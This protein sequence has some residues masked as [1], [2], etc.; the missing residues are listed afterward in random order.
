MTLLFLFTALLLAVLNVALIISI[1]AP[2]ARAWPPPGQKSWQF[3]ALWS[4]TIL[5]FGCLGLLGI[6]DWNRL[7]W[8]AELRWPVGLGLILAGNA[9]A[10]VGLTQLG[11]R[12]SSGGIGELVTS[13]IYKHSR[14]PAYIGDILILLEWV[15][16][17]ASVWVIAATSLAIVA[18]VLAPFAEEPWL[19]EIYGEEYRRYRQRTPR[20][21]LV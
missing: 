7:R 11:I 10:W 8:P 16:L 17:S 13:G 15:I 9:M 12:T 14:N 1:C 21:L 20:F 3:A 18:F 6:G 4:L 2:D 19:E 5:A